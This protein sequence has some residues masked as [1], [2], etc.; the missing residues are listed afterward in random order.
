MTVLTPETVPTS[1]SHISPQPGHPSNSRRPPALLSHLSEHRTGRERC[2]T[3]EM[4]TVSNKDM[5]AR[6][7]ANQCMGPTLAPAGET[8]RK[9]RSGTELRASPFSSTLFL[10]SAVDFVMGRTEEG[11]D[12]EDYA[13][14]VVGVGNAE[15]G[16]SAA[17]L[18]L[19]NQPFVKSVFTALREGFWSWATT[20]L[21]VDYPERWDHSWAPLAIEN[22][23][24]FVRKNNSLGYAESN[25]VHHFLQS[26]VRSV[27]ASYK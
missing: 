11:E 24:D 17:S 23:R 16:E 26:A 22:E 6:P 19:P 18:S 27:A 4:V 12:I 7:A 20:H 5:S 13:G 15:V 2:A 21:S 9:A 8:R 25:N 10:R 14:V 1:E 3:M